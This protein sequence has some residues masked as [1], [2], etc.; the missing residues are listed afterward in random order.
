MPKTHASDSFRASINSKPGICTGLLALNGFIG[1]LLF[2]AGCFLSFRFK[3]S[4]S[5]NLSQSQK[6]FQPFPWL[7]LSFLPVDVTVLSVRLPY[8]AYRAACAIFCRL[9]SSLRTA[10][11]QKPCFSVHIHNSRCLFLA[12][13]IILLK[14]NSFFLLRFCLSTQSYHVP[15]GIFPSSA[16]IILYRT[17]LQKVHILQ[18]LCRQRQL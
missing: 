14:G 3:F 18:F 11:R 15:E 6:H 2:H 7:R 12:S 16:H 5:E 4:T 10:V 9:T 17:Y 8:S 13:C 1:L